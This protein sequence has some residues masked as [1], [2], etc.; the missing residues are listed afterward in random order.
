MGNGVTRPCQRERGLAGWPI[1]CCTQRGVGARGSTRI[2]S[3]ADATASAPEELNV[4]RESAAPLPFYP[5][6]ASSVATTT[7]APP[8]G[9]FERPRTAQTHSETEHQPGLDLA[10]H[11]REPT[12][13]EYGE[14]GP[15][16][17]SNGH[18]SRNGRRIA[19]R[20]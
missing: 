5:Q 20:P 11:H 9:P 6:G 8:A 16:G 14:D 4:S 15:P 7:P 2:A 10:G 19:R 12:L 18:E 1:P 3:G 13:A 17:R